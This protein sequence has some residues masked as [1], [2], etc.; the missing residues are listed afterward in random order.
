MA[1]FLG[2]T[3]YMNHETC[4]TCLEI[5]DVNLRKIIA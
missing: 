1:Y 4:N 3:L 5:D 2:A